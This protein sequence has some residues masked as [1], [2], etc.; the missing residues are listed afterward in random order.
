MKRW[1]PRASPDS[2]L[3][4]P[5][6]MITDARHSGEVIRPSFSAGFGAVPPPNAATLVNVWGRPPLFAMRRVVPR[7]TFRYEGSLRQA[8]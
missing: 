8:W 3:L 4:L 5:G 2:S 1:L 7:R 6:G